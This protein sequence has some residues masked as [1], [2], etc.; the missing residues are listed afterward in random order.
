MS[1]AIGHRHAYFSLGRYSE[2]VESYEKGVELDPAN[3]SMKA[4]LAT[5]KSRLGDEDS[6]E[7]SVDREAGAT[8][9]PPAGNPLAGLMGGAGRGGMP[10]FASMMQNP[11]MMAM[12][13]QM[14]QGGGLERLMSNPALRSMADRAQ[15][16]GG[17]SGIENY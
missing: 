6:S 12:A 5:A 11:Q 14:M 9:P 4:S 17:V 8:S 10:D 7:I 13:Q 1:F 16:G 15:S 3:A 2:A